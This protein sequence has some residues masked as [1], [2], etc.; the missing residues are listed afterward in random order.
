MRGIK[1]VITTVTAALVSVGML[2][3][4]GSGNAGGA[5]EGLGTADKPVSIDFWAW[6]PVEDQWK[7]IIAEWEKENPNIKINLW[8]NA[9]QAE[10]EK[11]LRTAIAS[12]EGP[13]VFALNS[14][15]MVTQYGKFAD[16]MAK[17][18]DQYMKGWK[19][20]VSS[21][22]I[23][24]MT[25]KDGKLVG[26]PTLLTGQEYLLYNET[27]LKELGI[28]EMP[29]TYDELV[30]ICKQLKA[31]GL[32][33]IAYGA[34][35]IWHLVDLFVYLSNEFG[36]GDIY[37]A[38]DGKM[39]FTDETF[40]K[41]MKA[42]K[43]MADDQIFE[44]GAVGVPTYPDTNDNYFAER[45]TPFL[46]SGS[47]HSSM[48][49]IPEG[50]PGLTGKIANDT[51]GMIEFPQVG[52]IHSGP[53]TGVDYALTVNKDSKRKEASMKF[54][55]FMTTGKGQTLWTNM[56]QGS[57]V[58]TKAKVELRKDI[59]ETQRESVEMV[60][61][62]QSESKLTRKLKYADLENEI[63]VQMQNVYTGQSSVEDALASI[64]KVNESVDRG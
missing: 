4:C 19:D 60:N 14:G 64:E 9:D 6:Q 31:K 23:D 26:M 38:E 57:P 32:V 43:Q 27:F 49:V 48:V 53:T 8:R 37:K 39:K 15:S 44:D 56:L 28:T 45:K 2:A 47:W 55:E 5:D 62:T 35:D 41:T 25:D 29:K 50:M 13:D 22:A 61:K 46:A 7:P 1:K 59:T 12:G 36:E 21:T 17:L 54:I 34:K 10:Y 42:W 51:L 40:V 16:D 20:N 24:Q 30:K 63:G 18:S 11:K 3:A 58:Y 33:P 52:P